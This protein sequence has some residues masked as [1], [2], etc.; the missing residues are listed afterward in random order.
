M[1]TEQKSD[2]SAL[3][4]DDRDAKRKRRFARVTEAFEKRAAASERSWLAGL[5]GGIPKP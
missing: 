2:T 5:G 1:D 4:T 3:A